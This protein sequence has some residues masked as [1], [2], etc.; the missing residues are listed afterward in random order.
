MSAIG[1]IFRFDGAPVPAA[2]IAAILEAA[3]EVGSAAALW[4]PPSPIGTVALGCRPD[5]VTPEDAGYRSPV[6]SPDGRIVLVADAR[7]DNRA[8]LVAELGIP[9]DQ[10][11]DLSDAAL[12]L[13][14]YQAW[15]EDS[16]RHLVGDFCFAL[17]DERRH[18]LVAGRDALGQRVLFHHRTPGRLALATSP[19][20]LLALPDVP[21]RL[22]E[23]RVADFLVLYQEPET[24]FF[25]GINRVPAGHLMIATR[26]GVRTERFWSPAPRP[27]VLGSDADYVEGFRQVFGEAVRAQ[28]RSVGP[29]GVML[30]G[31]LDSASVAAVAARQL[32]GTGTR[33]AAFHAAPPRGFAGAVSPGWV[34]D[35][36][37]DVEA[38][39]GLHQN[40]DLSIHRSSG[41]IPFDGVEASFRAAGAPVRNPTNLRWFDGIY[42]AAQEAG[43][44]V[45]LTGHLG[46]ATISYHGF[47]SLRETARR[48]HWLEAI[49]EVRALARVTGKST[50]ALLEYQV[51]RPLL[52]AILSPAFYRARWGSRPPTWETTASPINPAFARAMGVDERLRISGRRDVE[53][54]RAGELAYRVAL[55]RAP[56]DAPD[57]YCGYRARFGLET[58]DPTADLRVVEYCLAIPGSQYLH[59]GVSRW[60]IRRAMEGFLPDQVRLRL[61]RG[62]QGPDWI[63]WLPTIRGELVA[64]LTRLDRSD[65]ARR[66]LDLA[67]LRGLVERWPARLGVEH[68]TDYQF[69]LLRG[70]MMGRFIRW[71]EG[72]YR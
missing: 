30:S 36:S 25:E 33:L 59:H 1:A 7:I 4:A 9:A 66:C 17:W 22:N 20:A 37:A 10:A 32:A 13:A 21:A 51:L 71:F 29:V 65:T 58:R 54:D 11:R 50:R 18:S 42:A 44:R 53:A 49:R 61:T 72:T 31:G 47:R 24:T 60:L 48:G 8:Q 38:I 56:A 5:G 27:I 15:G 19:Q 3:G 64:E 34:A 67:R 26:E 68:Q 39:A 23:Q 2:S 62:A 35:E 57:I 16:P 70:V 52:P 63:E 40:M 43:V 55:L 28:C 14:G 69:R 6:R 41:A 12:M 45:L 46:N